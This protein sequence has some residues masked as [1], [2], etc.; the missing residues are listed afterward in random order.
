MSRS[1]LKAAAIAVIF[2]AFGYGLWKLS[3]VYNRALDSEAIAHLRS[4]NLAQDAYYREYGIYAKDEKMLGFVVE[5]KSSQIFSR[6]E[7]LNSD[8]LNLI[9]K[10]LHPFV[11]ENAYIAI[12]FR[13]GNPNEDSKVWITDESKKIWSVNLI[14]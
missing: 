9:P 11:Q 6:T 12:L 4:Y 13:G 1:I 7:G 5:G 3:F 14:F 2:V 8:H 10:E